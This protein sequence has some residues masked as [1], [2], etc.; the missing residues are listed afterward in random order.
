MW[1]AQVY[2]RHRPEFLDVLLKRGRYGDSDHLAEGEEDG[3]EDVSNRAPDQ[4]RCPITQVFCAIH[5]VWYLYSSYGVRK[6]GGK[7]PSSKHAAVAAAVRDEFFLGA[8]T[9]GVLL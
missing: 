6:T 4:F 3:E 9:V 5:A 1:F 2:R 8:C 7:I